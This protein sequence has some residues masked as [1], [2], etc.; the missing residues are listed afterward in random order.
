MPRPPCQT[1]FVDRWPDELHER[2][3]IAH[4]RLLLAAP[5]LGLWTIRAQLLPDDLQARR[6]VPGRLGI[7]EPVTPQQFRVGDYGLL[8]YAHEHME[9]VG[10]N[11]V[12]ED[13][14][15]AVF[16]HL[17]ELPAQDLLGRTV[18]EPCSGHRPAQAMVHGLAGLRR[19]L[20]PRLSHATCQCYNIFHSVNAAVSSFSTCPLFPPSIFAVGPFVNA[21]L[22]TGTAGCPR[23]RQQLVS[24]LR[25]QAGRHPPRGDRE[26]KRPDQARL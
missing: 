13:L 6:L 9:M 10:E 8:R 17:P 15:P 23:L 3:N 5:V 11:G 24:E 21:A 25:R 7:E 22:R 20:D 19:H 14:D 4:Q 26:R 12:G 18:E 2:G 16:G 1:G